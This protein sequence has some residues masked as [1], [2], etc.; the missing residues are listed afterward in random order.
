MMYASGRDST[1]PNSELQ[2]SVHGFYSNKVCV[3]K[4]KECLR[5]EGHGTDLRITH[6]LCCI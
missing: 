5:R 6:K 4:Y 2:K 1:N 3:K